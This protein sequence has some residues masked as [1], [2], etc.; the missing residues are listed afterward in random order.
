MKF[1]EKISLLIKALLKVT[2]CR[3]KS[4]FFLLQI[5]H[6]SDMQNKI[7]SLITEEN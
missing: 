2:L 6:K 3:T 1:F 7:L 4:L 5:K